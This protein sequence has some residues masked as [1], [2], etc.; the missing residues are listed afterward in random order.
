MKSSSTALSSRIAHRVARAGWAAAVLLPLSYQAL[1]QESPADRPRGDQGFEVY[2]S[3]DALQALYTRAMSVGELPDDTR[4]RGG[5]F[6]NEERDLIGIGEMLVQ[7]LDT[8]RTRNWSLEVGPR[9]YGA[10]LSV[11][12]QDIFS[13]GLGGTIRYFF[14]AERRTGLGLT[15]Y[16]APDIVT[17]GAADD[18]T[19][20][21]I[22]FQTR[23]TD[24][25]E[26][27]IGYRSFE[28]DLDVPD[29]EV[30]DGLHL[31]LR[32]SL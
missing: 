31:G 4:L 30:D 24:R 2:L 1:A 10:L 11:E 15:A 27:F 16:Y 26:I 20:V 19:D 21:G 7:V 12:D 23:L 25:V 18:V 5:F 3:D 6:L 13:I 17:F 22:E 29:R 14:D 28:I 9:A 8:T 32:G